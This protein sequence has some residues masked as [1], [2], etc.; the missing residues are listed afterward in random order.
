MSEPVVII[1][2][3]QAAA[4]LAASLRQGGFTAP[5][6]MVGDECYAPYQRPPLSKKFFT[7]RAD[8][9]TL[10]LRTEK[11]WSDHNVSLLL[12]SAVRAVERADRTVA[13][14]NGRALK[15]GTLVFATG[16]RARSLPIPGLDLAGVYSLRAIDHVFALRAAVD[17]AAHTVII[18]GGYI[19]LEVAAVLRGEGRA[20][21][22]LEAA[23]RM[24]KRVAGPDVS[25]FYE[26][27][28]RDKGVELRTGVGVAALEGTSRVEAV[29]VADGE[30]LAADLVLVAAGSRANDDLAAA[31]GFACADGILV[32]AAAQADTAG[33]YAIGDCSR[34][35]SKRYDCRV[36]LENVQ[37]AVDQA[38]AA[39][40]AMLGRP[41]VYDPVP[42][43]WSDQYNLKLQ[44]VGLLTGYD[45]ARVAGD[46][47]AARFS[48]EY[49]KAGKLIALDA[50]NDARAYMIARKQMSVETAVV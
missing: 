9:K 36:R 25:G 39:A 6:T 7:E 10:Y 43:F 19:G 29:R 8:P 2:A 45:E 50:I 42:W 47:A 49:R 33:V 21:T 31:A 3:G 1:G 12:G 17:A 15:Y 18:G 5:I 14:A 27:F 35:H 24:L 28:H 40:A 38:K 34:F 11:Y 32:D 16:T 30:S 20:V 46:P 41:G 23:E 13:L 48:V 44:S 26:C 4:Q 37:N 22:V